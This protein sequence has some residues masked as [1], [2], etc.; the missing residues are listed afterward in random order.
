M[1]LPTV[2]CT[3]DDALPVESPCLNHAI[4]ILTQTKFVGQGHQVI[5]IRR[6]EVT[7]LELSCHILPT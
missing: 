2:G 6:S 3:R 4:L 7:S 5:N 1:L